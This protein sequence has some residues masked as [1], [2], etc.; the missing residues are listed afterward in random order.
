M[1]KLLG[2]EIPGELASYIADSPR[3]TG[4]GTA[5]ILATI[6]GEG[7]PHISMLSPW[8]VVVK[9]RRRLRIATYSSSRT[10][11]N[12]RERRLLTLIFIDRGMIYY[13]KGTASI[14]KILEETS[15]PISIFN[16]EV[17]QVLKEEGGG[18]ESGVTYRE[19]RGMGTSREILE[20]LNRD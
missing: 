14:D 19:E 13:V 9:T 1:A 7:W 8:E 6:D 4:R 11:G 15:P 5:I 2:S 16:I 17:A 20:A 18:V 3:G 12:L 10:S